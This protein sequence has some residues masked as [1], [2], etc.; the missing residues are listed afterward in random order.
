M[1]AAM[2]S[3]HNPPA[4]PALGDA[5]RL[6][7]HPELAAASADALAKMGLAESILALRSAWQALPEDA[8]HVNQCTYLLTAFGNARV[9]R[10]NGPLIA[11]DAE[12]D[13]PSPWQAVAAR[14]TIA[15]RLLVQTGTDEGAGGSI[16]VHSRHK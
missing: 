12:A 16:V 9:T 11:L 5:A 1:V 13:E 10:M 4:L 6:S 15:H 8:A 2:R 7:A 3:I 14:L